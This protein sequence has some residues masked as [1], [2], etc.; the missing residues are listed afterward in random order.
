M[1]LSSIA[2]LTSLFL[3]CSNNQ[4]EDARQASKPNNIFILA[5]DL[6]YG[7]LSCNNPESKIKT[8]HIDQ[9]AEKGLRFSD[10][11]SSAAVCTPSRYSILTGRYPWRSRLD[12][13]ITR[14]YQE[15]MIEKDRLTMGDMLQEMGYSTA[16]IGKWHLG[17][18][19][20]TTDG[21]HMPIEYKDLST[22][23]YIRKKDVFEKKIDFTSRSWK[24][25]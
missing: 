16:C 19:W 22:A 4:S 2:I 14:Q 13:G 3:A 25:Q 20:Q 23:D 12:H 24:A 1:K 6:G 21:S 10:A 17:M 15:A 7:D 9:L 11:H 18:R 5:D 8:P